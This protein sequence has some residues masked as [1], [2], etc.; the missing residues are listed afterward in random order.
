MDNELDYDKSNKKITK[1]FIIGLIICLVINGLMAFLVSLIRISSL[2]TE[3]IDY[4]LVLTDGF[5][6]SGGLMCLFY[7]LVFV[8]DEGAFDMLS[9]S[10]Q[11]VWN[12]TFHKNVRETK[13]PKTYAEYRAMKR[14]KPR[15]NLKFILSILTSLFAYISAKKE[16]LSTK[17]S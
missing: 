1:G 3:Q 13:L 16:I 9:Y 12:V 5:T 4:L 17:F 10:I 6:V 15:L 8:S 14:S 2:T 7:L 11:L